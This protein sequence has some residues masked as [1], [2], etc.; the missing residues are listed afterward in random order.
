[1]KHLIH[2]CC[3][4]LVVGILSCDNFIEA[5]AQGD[6]PAWIKY[7]VDELSAKTGESCEFISITKYEVRGKN[8]YNIDFGYSSCSTCNLFDE[9][10]NWVGPGVLANQ[11]ET[12]LIGQWPGCVVP[13]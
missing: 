12:K 7:K 3:F 9:N 1:L 13:K 11:S 2:F 8:F 5:P 6:N 4:F 10:G